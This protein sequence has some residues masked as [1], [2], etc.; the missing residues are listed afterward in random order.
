M[1]PIGQNL[2]MVVLITFKMVGNCQ[3]NLQLS[4]IFN[5]FNVKCSADCQKSDRLPSALQNV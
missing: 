1:V 5:A 4:I 3:N 2:N